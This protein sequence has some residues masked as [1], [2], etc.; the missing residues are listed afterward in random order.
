M[1][2]PGVATFG[3]DQR[4]CEQHS[5]REFDEERGASI[6]KALTQTEYVSDQN[7]ELFLK[8][9]PLGGSR[10]LIRFINM[11]MA[12]YRVLFVPAELVAGLL[13][14]DPSPPLTHQL[15]SQ[16]PEALLVLPPPSFSVMLCCTRASD[17]AI[18]SKLQGRRRTGR[19]LPRMIHCRKL[20]PLA[21]SL[22]RSFVHSIALAIL[23]LS[24]SLARPMLLLR[25]RRFCCRGFNS[26]CF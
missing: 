10:P 2:A 20:L 18:A 6:K 24:H 12:L 4:R 8:V 9:P 7:R 22:P 21:C 26:G 23:A 13:V 16:R 19:V 14:V 11:T 25:Q 5:K 15:V 1:Q 3:T 17:I